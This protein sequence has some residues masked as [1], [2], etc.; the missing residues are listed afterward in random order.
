M[1]KRFFNTFLQSSNKDKINTQLA[2][3]QVKCRQSKISVK[4]DHIVDCKKSQKFTNTAFIQA[5]KY[6]TF[7]IKTIGEENAKQ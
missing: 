1:Y 6:F 7:L 4:W 5:H 3:L 2:S